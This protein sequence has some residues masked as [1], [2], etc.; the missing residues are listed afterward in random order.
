M[1]TMP[2]LSSLGCA[3]RELQG[4]KPGG[5]APG[6][7]APSPRG[8]LSGASHQGPSPLT[9][10]QRPSACGQDGGPGASA[11]AWAPMAGGQKDGLLSGWVAGPRAGALLPDA[12]G[13]HLS[14]S[15]KASDD[16]QALWP[17]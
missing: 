17:H 8:W 3:G 6:L 12:H 15:S 16:C 9:W 1:G 13:A 10:E 5:Q 4:Q 11:L 2:F 7:P 14:V